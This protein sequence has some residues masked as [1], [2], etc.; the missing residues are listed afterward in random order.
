MGNA[1]KYPHLMITHL[2]V[3]YSPVPTF[4]LTAKECALYVVMWKSKSE[5]AGMFKEYAEC[6]TLCRQ[7]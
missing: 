3:Y 4:S 7:I 6:L 2:M 1:G 5:K